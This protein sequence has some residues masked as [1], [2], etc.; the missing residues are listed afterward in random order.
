MLMKVLIAVVLF[1]RP[2]FRDANYLAAAGVSV[3]KQSQQTPQHF[4]NG[5]STDNGKGH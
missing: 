3:S 2:V 1:S 5:R 4:P